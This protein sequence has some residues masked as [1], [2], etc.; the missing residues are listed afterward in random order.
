MRVIHS[1][2]GDGDILVATCSD[3]AGSAKLSHEGAEQACAALVGE[4]CDYLASH[5]LATVSQVIVEEWFLQVR[6]SLH[7][8]AGN[9]DV[10][11]RDLACT[12]LL[13]I[14]GPTTA[15]FA[16]LGDGAIVVREKNSDTLQAVFW[17]D[18][19][20]YANMTY[21]ITEAESLMHLRV[22]VRQGTIIEDVA[23]FTDGI[24][25]IA[26]QYHNKGVHEPFFRPLFSTLR[27]S[28]GRPASEIAAALESFLSSDRVNERTDDDKTLV[29]ASRAKDAASAAP[30]SERGGV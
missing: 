15:I 23:L 4:V 20:E 3:G 28:L 22:S 1:A 29:L 21:F 12:L 30:A 26:L 24:Q 19:G 18:S 7:D 14:V 10:S 6:L 25:A 5:S 2:I 9:L 11:S 17:P 27:R 16:H 13:A 8:L